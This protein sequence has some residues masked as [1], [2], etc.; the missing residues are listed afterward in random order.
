M[1]R[2]HNH[3]VR[4]T[5]LKKLESLAEYKF[6]RRKNGSRVRAARGSYIVV[7]TLSLASFTIRGYTSD[8]DHQTV[9]ERSPTLDVSVLHGRWL[10]ASEASKSFILHVHYQLTNCNFS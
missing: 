10:Q 4:E 5:V 7:R 9:M 6:I 1:L 3:I 8:Y 2:I